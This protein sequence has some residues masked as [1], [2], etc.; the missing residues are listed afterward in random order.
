MLLYIST[1]ME[2]NNLY[3]TSQNEILDDCWVEEDKQLVNVKGW[4]FKQSALD[5]LV[6]PSAPWNVQYGR[7][8]AIV[9]S[10]Q[11]HTL[12]TFL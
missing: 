12:Q 2:W 10:G 11:H 8:V 9:H 5:T 7:H 4:N 6:N 3:R 1:N